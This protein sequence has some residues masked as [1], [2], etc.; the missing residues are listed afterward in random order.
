M[1]QKLKILIR[2]SLKITHDSL[3]IIVPVQSLCHIQ[4][5]VNPWVAARQT[6]LSS[7]ISRSL[8]KFISVELV[9][10]SNRHICCCHFHFCPQSFPASGS[11][12]MHWLF[13][14]GGQSIAGSRSATI[15]MMNIQGWFSLGLIGLI[16][17]QSKGLI[18]VF[19]SSTFQNDQSFSTQ[20]SLWSKSQFHSWLL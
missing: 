10:L 12:P 18:R 5:F 20:T 3:S 11:F 17:L 1:F 6:P 4:L 19:I 16:S 13:A 15:L 7:T 2:L 9:M 8:L 14:A